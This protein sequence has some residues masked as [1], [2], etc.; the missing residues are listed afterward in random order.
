MREVSTFIGHIDHFTGF[1]I[2]EHYA[3]LNRSRPVVFSVADPVSVL[4]MLSRVPPR[5]GLVFV[6]IHNVPAERTAEELH[7]LFAEI[8][9]TVRESEAI[10]VFL[11]LANADKLRPFLDG[12][13]FAD[14][15]EF[16]TPKEQAGELIRVMPGLLLAGT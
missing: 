5:R 3:M 8:D 15:S 16:A 12:L 6:L 2:A 4:R 13:M 11:A 1:S 10:P 14:L 7:W 9:A